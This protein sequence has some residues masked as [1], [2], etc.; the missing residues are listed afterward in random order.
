[1]GKGEDEKGEE[2]EAEKEEEKKEEVAAEDK[3]SAPE[4]KGDEEM[5]AA[6][7]DDVD[8]PDV[9]SVEDIND[10]GSGKPLY[11]SFAYEDWVLLSLR[12]EL[13]LL[14]HAFKRDL[15]DPDRPG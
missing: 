15:N 1:M 6:A 14:A 4:K 5:P 8:E 12:F 9:D 2:K 10:I 3:E 13:H 7:G 11:F